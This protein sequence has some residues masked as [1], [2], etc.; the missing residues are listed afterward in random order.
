[1][2]PQPWLATEASAAGSLTAVAKRIELW[3]IDQL[4]AYASIKDR[5]LIQSKGIG[6]VV[7]VGRRPRVGP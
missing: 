4:R 1:M 7:G 2:A 3:P 6:L 5:A